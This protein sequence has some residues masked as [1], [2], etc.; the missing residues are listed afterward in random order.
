VLHSVGDFGPGTTTISELQLTES[1]IPICLCDGFS[2]CLWGVIS[3]WGVI[4]SE[5]LCVALTE[6]AYL[7]IPGSHCV[8]I[9]GSLTT[10]AGGGLVLVP[11]GS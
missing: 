9:S 11:D 7:T 2:A 4:L 10:H 8:A 1:R 3:L 6:M 5:G